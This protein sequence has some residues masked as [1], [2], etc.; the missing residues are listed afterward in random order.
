[1]R[2]LLS[3]PFRG[4][5]YA[6]RKK[7]SFL[8]TRLLHIFAVTNCGHELFEIQGN[9][10]NGKVGIFKNYRAYRLFIKKDYPKMEEHAIRTD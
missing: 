3:A 5:I 9:I 2:E 7:F 4:Y 1:M 10:V 6:R 8:K